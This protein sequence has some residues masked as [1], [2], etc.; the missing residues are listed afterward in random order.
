MPEG[1]SGGRRGRPAP[2]D[3]EE[4]PRECGGTARAASQEECQDTGQRGAGGGQ[5][6]PKLF[7]RH[8][9]YIFNPPHTLPPLTCGFYSLNRNSEGG[10]SPPASSPGAPGCTLGRD[11]GSTGTGTQDLVRVKQTRSPR[12]YR[13]SPGTKY[14]NSLAFHGTAQYLFFDIA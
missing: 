4:A 5:G 1:G 12:R 9:L 10:A 8:E 11:C 2:I 6:P 14:F 7:H 13:T 3:G